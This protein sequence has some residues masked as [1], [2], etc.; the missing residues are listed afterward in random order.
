MYGPISILLSL[1]G[2]VLVTSH[3]A[4][5]L[6]TAESLKRR[7]RSKDDGESGPGGTGRAGSAI[8]TCA[9]RLSRGS[10]T[11][12][13][14]PL[15]CLRAATTTPGFPQARSAPSPLLFP[16]PH[17][18]HRDPVRIFLPD[19]FSFLFPIFKGM[20]LLVLELHDGPQGF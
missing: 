1:K 2:H 11:L 15:L 13:T 9:P 17:Y 20:V 4:H 5:P 6:N 8:G 16:A 7:L 18:T 19:F 3:P 12:E 10:A 14:T